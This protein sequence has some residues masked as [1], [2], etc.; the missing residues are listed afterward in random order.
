MRSLHPPIDDDDPGSGVSRRAVLQGAAAAG[1]AIGYGGWPA[2]V[3]GA[4]AGGRTREWAEFDTAVRSSF[5]RMGMVGAAVAVVSADQVLYTST[6]G[7]RDQATNQPVTNDTHF[8]VASTTKSMSSLLAATFVDDNLFGWDQPVIEVWPQFRAPTDELTKTLRVRDLMGMDSGITEPAALSGRHEGDP[9]APQLLQSVVN[10]P[11]EYPP[12]STFFY[13]N[14]LYAVGGYLPALAQ[15]VAGA[16]LES[17]YSQQMH[18]RVYGPG[19]METATIAD[20]PRGVVK[21]YARG[22]GPDL[23]GRRLLMPYG[24]VGSYMPVGGTLATLMDMAAYVRLQLRNGT[25]I[26]G[27]EVV[28]AVNLAE[29]WKPHVDVPT[30]PERWCACTAGGFDPDAVSAGYGMGWVHQT[31]RDGTSLVWHSGGIDGFTTLIGFLPEHDI[32]LVVLNNMNPGPLGLFFDQA[33]LNHLLSQRFGFNLG[34]NERIE[35]AYDQAI[36]KFRETWQQTTPAD[37]AAV[38]PYAGYYQ[39]GYRLLVD[40]EVPEIRIG[41]RVMPLR[42]LS[43]GAYVTTS[44]TDPG[45]R[46]H[47]SRGSDGVSRMELEGLET[48]S[49]TVGLD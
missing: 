17:T 48:V 49:R 10:L 27:V 19:G 23:Q 9:T 24:A 4:R 20:D 38:A 22:Y 30:S 13:N 36:A 47:L 6:H 5:Q 7:L 1:L 15:G 28:S 33:V 45:L 46:V 43:D 25:S 44:G 34:V 37:Y 32:G 14:T 26:D 8:L 40:R 42:A 35:A 16:D 18:E 39:G 29:C 21:R 31:Y 3:L 11:V 41:S 12:G 2:T